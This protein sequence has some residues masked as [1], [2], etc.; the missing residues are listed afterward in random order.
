MYAAYCVLIG[1]ISLSVGAQDI[2]APLL[3]HLRFFKQTLILWIKI[4]A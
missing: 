4:T 2:A 3:Q 1:K